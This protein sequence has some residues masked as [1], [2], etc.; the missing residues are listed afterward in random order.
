MFWT[1]SVGI[2]YGWVLKHKI[3]M[4]WREI[5]CYL[6]WNKSGANECIPGIMDPGNLK[7]SDAYLSIPWSSVCL[8]ADIGRG[9]D[10]RAKM[11]FFS[12]EPYSSRAFQK[13]HIHF[14]L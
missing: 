12:A 3:D 1:K 14:P 2:T 13:F 11:N 4:T 7:E 6:I 10:W 9:E 8:V 5:K